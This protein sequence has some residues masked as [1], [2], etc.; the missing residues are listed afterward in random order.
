MFR[1]RKLRY[2]LS[3][4]QGLGLHAQLPTITLRGAFGYA[5][6][7][8]LAKEPGLADQEAR[9][10][11]F[12]DF[13]RPVDQ[14]NESSRYHDMAR[15]FVLRGDYNGSARRSFLLELI[16][17]GVACQYESFFD[18][19]IEQLARQ[20]VGINNIPCQC[21]KLPA[22]EVQLEQLPEQIATNTLLIR[23]LTP[24]VR[25]KYRGQVFH[26]EIPFAALFC[27][28][29][30]RV[31]ELDNL[32]GDATLQ[33]TMDA[34][35]LKQSSAEISS[36]RLAGGYQRAQRISTRTGQ[37]IY[38]NGFVGIMKYTGDFSPYHRILPYL[39][40][41]NIG[42]SNCFGCG[43]CQYEFHGQKADDNAAEQRKP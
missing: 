9:R 34:R 6:A 1:I 16:V 15:P 32:Y 39:P 33:E 13:F 11:L 3:S 26:E 18:K 29:Y 23:F 17:F 8:I 2:E 31:I 7:E 22:E 21:K 42:H 19:V 40:W 38:L 37:E 10:K 25:I 14:V 28:L 41:V 24:C 4:S 36:I 35:T 12:Q 43:W 30:D 5:L 20:G 27:R